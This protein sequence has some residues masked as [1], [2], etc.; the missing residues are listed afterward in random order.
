MP[1]GEGVSK[2]RVNVKHD[3]HGMFHVQ[4]AEMMKEVVKVRKSFFLS[5]CFFSFGGFVLHELFR[6]F[7]RNIFFGNVPEHV[8]RLTCTVRALE[9]GCGVVV[10]QSFFTEDS[11]LTFPGGF[12]RKLCRG[13][14][15]FFFPYTL[16]FF[17]RFCV[18]S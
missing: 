1:Q 3:I 10:L 17:L 8:S 12:F 15:S 14:G 4:S 11:F 13:E 7:L 5:M 9:F 6:S 16:V 18:W 2:V